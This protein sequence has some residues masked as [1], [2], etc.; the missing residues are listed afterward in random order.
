MST[1]FVDINVHDGSQPRDAFYRLFH[2]ISGENSESVEI[3]M[4]A[5]VTFRLSQNT[6]N[7]NV[8]NSKDF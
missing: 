8:F 2:F 1:D 3:P 4:T 7:V 6:T 5:P